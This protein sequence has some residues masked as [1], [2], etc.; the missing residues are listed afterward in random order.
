MQKPRYNSHARDLKPFEP[1]T[2]V[3]VQNAET[4]EWDGTA[5]IITR[6][7]NLQNRVVEW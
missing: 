7:R 6:V 5:K 3:W 1:G 4:G 2:T